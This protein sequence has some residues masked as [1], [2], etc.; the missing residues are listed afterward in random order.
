[1]ILHPFEPAKPHRKVPPKPAASEP[2]AEAPAPQPSEA[3]PK[4]KKS[5]K[6]GK[7]K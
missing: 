6:K 7:A 5:T 4:T 1:M 3:D 2:A